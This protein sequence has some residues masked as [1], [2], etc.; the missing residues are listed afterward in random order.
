MGGAV[1]RTERITANPVSELAAFRAHHKA[2]AKTNCE[3]RL[4]LK[5]EDSSKDRRG[6]VRDRTGDLLLGLTSG[7]STRRM[8]WRHKFPFRLMFTT[9]NS[10]WIGVA[11]EFVRRSWPIPG[12]GHRCHAGSCEIVSRRR[13]ALR[14][15]A[16]G[17]GRRRDYRRSLGLP[18]SKVKATTP[19]RRHHVARTE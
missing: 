11:R 13:P 7:V 19:D 9:I 10:V 8:R 15:V 18:R 3:Q 6:V 5:R 16:V 4:H 2:R 17:K 12:N 1:G 14:M